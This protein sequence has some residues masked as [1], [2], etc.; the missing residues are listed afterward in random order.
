MYAGIIAAGTRQGGGWYA[1]PQTTKSRHQKSFFVSGKMQTS[2][3]D[4]FPNNVIFTDR[5]AG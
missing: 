4:R 1:V 5:A 2:T 3:H